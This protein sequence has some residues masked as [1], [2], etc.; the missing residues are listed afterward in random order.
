M[1]AT[2]EISY[3]N[4]FILAG[5]SDNTGIE[6]KP[7]V[8]HIEESRIKG[9]YNETSV[10]LGVK[11]YLVDDEYTSRIRGNAMMYSGI[12]NAKTKVNETNQ[13]SIGEPI[14]KAV[15]I[16]NGGIQKLYAEDTNLVIFQ[17][18][19]VSKAAID[20]DIIYTQEGQ[21]LTTASQLV[22]G[23]VQAFA[24]KYGISKNPE[25]FAVYG[26]RKYFTDKN[27]GLVLRLS[28]DGITPISDSG[29]RTF[30]REN[31]SI[32]S[33][34]YG[35][36]DEQKNKY[37]VS[38][39]KVINRNNSLRAN[40]VAINIDGAIDLVND[41]VTLSFDETS[42]GWVS[43]YTYNPTF[44]L[45]LNNKFYTFNQQ[46]LWE[47]YKKT[48]RRCSFYG[49][50]LVDPASIEFV[51]NDQPNI[52]K[53]FLTIDYEGTKN[54]EMESA[55]TDYETA[56]PILRSDLLYTVNSIPI[57]FINKENKYH[58]YIRGNT[59]STSSGQVT[60]VSL[61]GIKGYYNK[62]KMQYWNPTESLTSSVLNKAE[63]FAVSSETVFS[64]Q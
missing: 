26:N 52:I 7:G 34:A 28:Q 61:S 47:H 39:Q 43:F 19:K 60:G 38:I 33:N 23:Q 37:I 16:A 30:F 53:N 14:T 41:Y 46:N 15:D 4:T 12:F 18:N 5:G 54:W 17:E 24:G 51:L 42:G 55:T 44:G 50:P 32:A 20:K 6:N 11:A 25:S 13:F 29:M 49:N 40:R 8:W 3:F 1:A 57:K 63:L 31:L 22:I 48:V 45:S 21:P 64:S 2:I 9:G 35:M 62:V 27:R 36:Y 58:G 10:D 56:Y 59:T